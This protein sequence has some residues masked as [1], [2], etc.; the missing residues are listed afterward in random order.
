MRETITACANSRQPLQRQELLALGKMAYVII[1]TTYVIRRQP[2]RLQELPTSVAAKE[3]PCSHFRT[4][5]II[6]PE[7]L[8]RPITSER[9]E[10]NAVCVDR[11]VSEVS[12]RV[13][14]P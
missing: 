3:Y 11:S 4:V 13:N 10:S 1:Y 14:K 7:G 5:S 9:I 2:L 12:K 6:H 8:G